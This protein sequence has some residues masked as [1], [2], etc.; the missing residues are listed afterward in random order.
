M[1]TVHV[2]YTVERDED[3]VWCAHAWLGASGGANGNGAMP[4]VPPVP[5]VR[6]DRLV[7]A[8]ERAGFAVTRGPGQP[9]PAAASRRAVHY[10]PC[11][12]RRD[13][14]KGTLRSVLEDTGLTVE[15]LLKYL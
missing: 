2:P 5:A 3:G 10:G 14:P 1:A 9:S 7:R 4:E 13:V 6:G 12:S 8:L 15:K 11:A